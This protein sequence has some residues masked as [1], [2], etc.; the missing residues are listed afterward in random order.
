AAAQLLKDQSQSV[1]L[2]ACQGLIAGGDKRGIRPLIELLEAESLALAWQAEELLHFVAGNEG[3]KASVESGRATT[4]SAAVEEWKKWWDEKGK[5]VPL[6]K[7]RMR[8]Q[9][10]RLCLVTCGE[11][12]GK[13]VVG[14]V[15]IYGGNGTRRWSWQSTTEIEDAQ[16]LEG[17]R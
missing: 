12:E 2:R 13:G 10:P 17:D 3:P 4:R 16:V 1:R 6:G 8:Q 15:G 14:E 5:N 9:R 11:R 7:G